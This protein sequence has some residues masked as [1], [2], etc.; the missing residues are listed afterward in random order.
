MFGKFLDGF[1]KQGFSLC[2]IAL[3]L[4]LEAQI[5][6]PAAELASHS[7]VGSPTLRGGSDSTSRTEQQPY[8]RQVL[9][10]RCQD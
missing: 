5:S 7:G 9:S 10:G 4:P 6:G 3:V 1:A 2:Q 8:D